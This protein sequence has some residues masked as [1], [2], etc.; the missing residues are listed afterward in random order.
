MRFANERIQQMVDYIQTP[1]YER[2]RRSIKDP[3]YYGIGEGSWRREQDNLHKDIQDSSVPNSEIRRELIEDWHISPRETDDIIKWSSNPANQVSRH[4]QWGVPHAGTSEEVARLALEGSGLSSNNINKGNHYATDLEVMIDGVK[5]LVD[6]Q[7]NYTYPGLE[8]IDTIPVLTNVSNNTAQKVF[9]DASPRDSIS[10][11]T[12][13]IQ[14]IS[15]RHTLDK[16]LHTQRN[17]DA[18]I[19]PQNQVKDMLIGGTFDTTKIVNKSLRPGHGT[20]NPSVPSGMIVEDLNKLRKNLGGM[21]KA[22]LLGKDIRGDI[23]HNESRKLKLRIPHKV[24]EELSRP[25]SELIT[26][27]VQEVLNYLS[28]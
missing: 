11:I 25:E 4:V 13:E 5:R 9:R 1:H 17:A 28:L 8:R 10:A 12:E 23:L 15:P 26:R 18:G 21:T 24:V 20:Y 22:E 16:L 3:Y 19:I 2:T 27:D 6:V 7:N 14:R